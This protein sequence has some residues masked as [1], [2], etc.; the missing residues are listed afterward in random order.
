MNLEKTFLDLT[1]SA[2]PFLPTSRN[3]GKPNSCVV[4]FLF[5]KLIN[6]TNHF[7]DNINVFNIMIL[8][9][10]DMEWLLNSLF[11]MGDLS[12]LMPLISAK[13]NPLPGEPSGKANITNHKSIGEESVSRIVS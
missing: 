3:T 8:G 13:I 5:G 7:L 10:S 12:N 4:I 2:G 6:Q 1:G 9:V 11:E